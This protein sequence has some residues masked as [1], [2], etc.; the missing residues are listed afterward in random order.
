MYGRLIPIASFACGALVGVGAAADDGPSHVRPVEAPR[1]E[2]H[3]GGP[4]AEKLAAWVQALASDVYAERKAATQKLLAAGPAAVARLAAAADSADLET[5]GRCLRILKRLANSSDAATKQAATRA[6]QNLARSPHQYVSRQAAEALIEPPPPITQAQIRFGRAGRFGVQRFGVPVQPAR[7]QRSL[8]RELTVVD[9]GRRITFR[10][11]TGARRELRIRIPERVEGQE[12]TTEFKADN[13]IELR[14]QSPAAADLY[15]KYVHDLLRQPVQVVAGNKV[16]P[17]RVPVAAAMR[18]RIQ[19]RETGE[20]SIHVE[21]NGREIQ[22]SDKNGRDIAIRISKAGRPETA[23]YE[24]RDLD[25]LKQQHP[26]E[27]VELYEKYASGQPKFRVITGPRGVPIETVPL[28]PAVPDPPAGAAPADEPP[29][30][31]SPLA[32]E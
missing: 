28:R 9:N 21:D 6:L 18:I 2:A 32:P 25:E 22:I 5:P 15:D 13:A 24:A 20:R 17:L 10:Y 8:V 23:E 27:V 31:E 29:A 12:K 30:D 14:K 7:L 26:A 16:L 11:E 1:P 19:T 3:G 4:S